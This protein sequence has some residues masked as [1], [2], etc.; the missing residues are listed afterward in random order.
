MKKIVK[1]TERDLTRIVN[2]V[3][4][5]QIAGSATGKFGPGKDNFATIN[6]TIESSGS[7]TF[8]YGKDQIDPNNTNIKSIV[9]AIKKAIKDAKGKN[10]TITIDGGSSAVG[11]DRGYNNQALAKRRR[12]NFI[13]YLE[14]LNLGNVT[15]IPGKATVGKESK[16]GTA[17][18]KEQFVKANISYDKEQ[19]IQLK[20][21]YGDNT[22]VAQDYLYKPP[23]D[24][25]FLPRKTYK[26]LSFSFE[27]ESD[28]VDDFKDGFFKAMNNVVNK[29][30]WTK[31]FKEGC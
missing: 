8:K 7:N 29:Y 13:D 31:N 11:S 10:V 20:G 2:E 28:R 14:N 6:N 4:S 18:E 23:K 1:L 3:I 17:A 22:N 30:S 24:L 19:Q 5:E 16:K 9:S 21:D 25:T 26:K 12:D 15:I 27:V